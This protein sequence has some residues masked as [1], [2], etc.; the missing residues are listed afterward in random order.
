M[1]GFGASAVNPYLAFAT[2]RE[3]V[4]FGRLK[5]VEL[6]KALE[7]YEASID[8]GL[9]KIMS[10]MGISTVSGYHAMPRSSRR[11]VSTTRSVES[12]SW[13]SGRAHGS[14]ESVCSIWPARPSTG[15]QWL[16][17]ETAKLDEGGYYRIPPDGEYHSWKPRGHQRAFHRARD[18]G[19]YEEYK[20][21]ANSVNSRPP[22]AICADL[23]DFSPDR[24]PISIEDVEPVSEV[25]KKF[26]TSAMSLG[27]LSPEAHE[28]M[29]IGMNRM[30][31]KSNTGE[32][33][34]DPRRYATL[35]NGDTSNSKIK[36]WSLPPASALRRAIWRHG[37]AVRDQDGPGLEAW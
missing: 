24:E 8:A 16:S 14:A 10:K 9:L 33:G 21:Y 30:G 25:L 28:T 15:M 1:L 12:R 36:L 29:A 35:P 11:L 26:A 13:P 19:T 22:I 23:L 2:L 7:G 32:G 34:E 3:M 4:L 31:G 37:R 5:D 6:S 18:I 27:A 17:L 20:A